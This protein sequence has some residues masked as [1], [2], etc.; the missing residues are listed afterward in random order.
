[1][2]L[3]ITETDTRPCSFKGRLVKAHI[4]IE[5]KYLHPRGKVYEVRVGDVHLK[6]LFTFHSLQRMEKWGITQATLLDALLFPEEV[7]LPK[8]WIPRGH[9]GRYIAQKRLNGHVIR[10]IYEYVEGMPAIVT[11]YV[12]YAERYYQGGNTYEDKILK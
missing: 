9:G 7:L 11:V 3:E 8:G 4:E 2:H 6:I 12:P 10:V 1:M 5:T